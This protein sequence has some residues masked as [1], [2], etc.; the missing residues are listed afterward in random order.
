MH[1][2]VYRLPSPPKIVKT[3]V[4]VRRVLGYYAI[5]RVFD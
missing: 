2:P 1:V 3:F 5:S 4:F